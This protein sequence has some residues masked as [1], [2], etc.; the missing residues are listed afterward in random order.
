MNRREALQLAVTLLGGALSAS[1]TRALQGGVTA[2][3]ALGARVLDAADLDTVAHAAERILPRTESPGAIDAGVPDFI[4]RVVAD[5]Y[6][7]EERAIFIDGLRALDRDARARFG[8]AFADAS[9]T[10]QIALLTALEAAGPPQS[11]VP[12]G[13]AGTAPF[14]AKLKELTVLGYYTSEVAANAEL[15]YR[16]V[17]GEYRGDALFHEHGRQ[18]EY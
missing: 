2:S 8:T 18:W 11:G 14:F 9:E 5:W 4:H 6:S 1:C 3:G 10:Q 17:P 15:V 12:A 7:D 13:G 16:P